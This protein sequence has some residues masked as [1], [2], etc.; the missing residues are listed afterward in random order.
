MSLKIATWNVNSVR[1]RLDSVLSWI[2]RARPDVLCMQEIKVVDDLFPREP[3][4]SR[5]YRVETFG[6]KTY[7]GVALLSRE[8]FENVTRGFPDDK[9]DADRRLIAATVAGIRIV[10]VYVPNGRAVGSPFFQQKL[11]WLRRLR[12]ALEEM[13]SPRDDLVLCG[14]FNVAP[15]DRD[16]YDP[17]GYRDQ[18]HCHPEERKA[19]A[20]L[21]EYGLVDVLRRHHAE[22]GLYSWWDYRQGAFRRD[23]GLRIDIIYAT[24]ALAERCAAVT[25]D[26]EPRKGPAPSD[27]TP[28][29]AEITMS[30]RA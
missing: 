10:N 20:E 6:Q 4:A 12:R 11:D 21:A 22:G 1:A 17:E 24:A 9:S 5:G 27:H 25:I 18:L 19:L 2:D 28:V 15:D 8:P 26:R 23:L 30:A 29:V 13:T 7:N 16:V 3:F 14:D